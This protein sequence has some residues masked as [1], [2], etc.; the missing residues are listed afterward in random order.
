V[1]P[2]FRDH[3][4]RLSLGLPSLATG[5]REAQL[6]AG[7][8]LGAHWTYTRGPAQIVLPTGTGKT[9]VMTLAPFLKP[10][11]RVLVVAPGRVVRDQLVAAFT[12]FADLKRTELMPADLPQ[13][14]VMSQ[15]GHPTSSTWAE[16]RGADVVVGNVHNLSPHYEGVPRMPSS[17]FDLVLV[18]EGHHVPAEAW[19]ALLEAADADAA[20]FTATPFRRD[21]RRIPGDVVYAYPLRRAI[22]AGVYSPVDFRPVDPG[23]GDKDIALA[24]AS[25][26]R[27]RSPEHE[28]AGSRLLIRAARVAD[29]ERLVEVYRRAGADVGLVVGRMSGRAVE[30]TIG[31]A[32]RAEIDGLVCVAGLI[33]GFDLPTLRIAAY[34]EPHRTLAPTLQFV[35]RLARPGLDVRG[36]LLAVPEDIA[37]ET[38]ELF[39]EEA[40]WA[41]LL[42]A[43][44]D[45]AVEEE[46]QVRR[47]VSR[48]TARG[49]VDVPPLAIRPSR[50]ARI[51]PVDPSQIDL[52]V[53]PQRLGGADVVYR[54][55]EPS[56]DILALITQHRVTPRWP[57]ADV[58]DEWVYELHVTC[59][60]RDPGVLFVAS[61]VSRV[62]G[63]LR[64]LIGADVAVPVAGDDLR[65]LLWAVAPDAYFSVG[66]RPTR[67]D[68]SSYRTVAGPRAD[69]AL[70]ADE[71]RTA[72]LGH[73]MGGGGTR[74]FGLSVAKAKLWE[75]DATHGLLD[76]R[77]WCEERAGDLRES[78]ALR[79]GMPRLQV[80]ISE[81]FAA[82]PDAP[83]IA[84][85]LEHTM[86]T[87]ELWPH[88]GAERVHAH[89]LAL[90]AER[91]S[92]DE[93]QLEFCRGET[94]VWLGTQAPD[95]SLVSIEGELTFV[96]PRTGEVFDVPEAFDERPPILLFGDGSSVQGRL[97]EPGRPPDR[98]VRHEVLT[99]RSWTD[100]AIQIEAAEAPAGEVNVQQATFE[101]LASASSI[102]L[103]DHGNGE[104][105]D[106][107]GV[108]LRSDG[109]LDVLLAHCKAARDPTPRRQLGDIIEVL[110]QA[111]RS[112]RW[113]DPAAGLWAELRARLDSRPTYCKVIQ[114][115]QESVKRSLESW[116]EARR[117]IRLTVTVVQPGLD[118]TQVAGWAAGETLINLVDEWCSSFGAEFRLVGS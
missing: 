26:E 52:D 48:A 42:P 109:E 12:T 22:E 55:Y 98:P 50:S 89:E 9:L 40:V 44:V 10:C 57:H 25:I 111:A 24:T 33:E 45:E 27:L 76:F 81:R 72:S 82:F 107:V 73:V 47:H 43:L 116:A 68:G 28:R 64:G 79:R 60:V 67:N 103:T 96:D 59:L 66:L 23:G 37:E 14:Q 31:R 118:L 51:Y 15:S 102:V 74:T 105:A 88:L 16:C 30:R 83:V 95:G 62:L 2:F 6:G 78:V 90:L 69:I 97:L 77:R 58:L 71:Q 41:E 61:D 93:L 91:L 11:R 5:L 114:G 110:T 80:S 49:R 106:V 17:L 32:R 84:T 65:R 18:D 63:D 35:G 4:P 101:A 117:P 3:A 92:D 21:R 70:R 13:P 85:A 115:E 87:E 54:F 29:A 112:A 100:V 34:H 36:E 8:A 39:R 19:R 113:A 7:W 94:T 104:L 108:T 86:I 53:D 38:E 20:F 1:S 99:P 75:P 56:T 46:R